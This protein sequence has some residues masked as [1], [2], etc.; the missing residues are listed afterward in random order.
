MEKNTFNVSDW[1]PNEENKK[2]VPANTEKPAAGPVSP[3]AEPVESD[4]EQVISSLEA[5]QLDIT[6]NYKDWLNCGFALAD[7]LGEGG[8]DYFH[9]ISRFYHAYSRANCD[10]QYDQ[11]LKAKGHGITI[12]TFYHLAQQAG[13]VIGRNDSE[14]LEALKNWKN[15]KGSPGHLPYDRPGSGLEEG[16][17]DIPHIFNTPPLPA[18]VYQNLPEIL[19]DCCAL[20]RE[21]IEQDVFLISSLTVLS[22]CL[23]NIGGIYFDNLHS[24]HLYAFITAPAGS[25]KG[26]MNWAKYFG[27]V[28]HEHMTEQ[29]RASRADYEIEL[30]QYNSLTKPQRQ[31]AVKPEE[32]QR[33]MFYI[34]A[35]SSS[36]AFTQALSDNKFRGV[37]FETEADTLAETFKQDWGNFSDVLRKAF[38]HEGTSMFRRKDNEFIEIRDPHLAIALS[39]TPKQVHNLMPDTENGLFSRF[40]YYAFEDNSDFKNPFVS[41]HPAN[42]PDFFWK[43]GLAIFELYEQLNFQLKPLTFK[44]TDEQGL[45]F[46]ENFNTML[47][48]NKLLLGRDL[49]ANI[50]RLGLI[51]FRIAMILSALRILETDAS[52]LLSND[53]TEQETEPQEQRYPP[54]YELKNPLICSDQDYETAMA[55]TTTLQQHAVA[56]YQN[57]P[58]NELKGTRLLFYERLPQKFNRKGYLKVAEELGIQTKTAEKYLALFIPKLL[59]HVHNEYTKISA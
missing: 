50:K 35:N 2:S 25:G 31:G 6:S 55:I 10:Q 33:R 28:I 5:T 51:T 30:E 26:K 11:C 29:S 59:S 27:T 24:A 13:V 45:R 12:K 39:G 56:V 48:K 58:N 57:M 40:L 22:G 1:L 41:H 38:H 34:P 32:P 18:K 20:F 14:R 43:K 17:L 15:W 16:S 54:C 8:R 37:I 46:T 21:G 52:Q 36:S 23:P 53:N 44:L 47:V 3:P 49:D 9:R 4:L 19:S 42:F 7:E